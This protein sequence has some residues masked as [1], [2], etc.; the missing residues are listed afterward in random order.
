[1]QLLTKSSLVSFSFVKAIT[2]KTRRM[3]SFQLLAGNFERRFKLLASQ[4]IASWNRIVGWLREMETF[5]NVAALRFDPEALSQ[6][7]GLLKSL[8]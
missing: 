4:S 7:R 3:F 5:R 8:T 6:N 1:M 2:V